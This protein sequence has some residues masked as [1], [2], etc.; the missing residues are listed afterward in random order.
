MKKLITSLAL[1]AATAIANP[2]ELGINASLTGGLNTYNDSWA[3]SERG[4]F[5]WKAKFFGEAHK[6]FVEK[7]RMEN[8]LNFEFGQTLDQELTNDGSYKRSW[9]KAYVSS[10]EIDFN[11]REILTLKAV[12]PYFGFRAQTNFND[13][14]PDNDSVQYLNPLKFTES[15]GISKKLLED[16]E[17]QSLEFRLAGAFNQNVNRKVNT[18]NDGGIEFITEYSVENSKGY[19]GYKTYLNLYKALAVSDSLVRD[20]KIESVDVDWK[21]EAYVNVNRFI[22]ITYSMRMLYN[23]YVI[24]EVQMKN[25]LTAGLNII[26]SNKETE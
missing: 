14:M 19:L 21:N 13:Q 1:F 16:K 3:G 24:D 4:N 25:S 22:V 8:T 11:N 12:S 23:K 20:D 18:I 10:D 17:K 5:V 6:Q 26:K 9:A 7:F 2:W 15:I